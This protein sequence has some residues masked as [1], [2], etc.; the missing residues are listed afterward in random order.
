MP[1]ASTPGQPDRGGDVVAV[2][3]RVEIPGCP[4]V[5]HERLAGEVHGALGDDLA[6]GRGR[7]CVVL[8][9]EQ[10]GRGGDDVRRPRHP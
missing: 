8:P 5:A 6:D 9:D 4:G 10:H 2:V 7:S 1:W 3:D